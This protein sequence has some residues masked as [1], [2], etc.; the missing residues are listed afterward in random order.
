MT[1]FLFWGII[2]RGIYMISNGYLWKLH[3]M[4]VHNYFM[5]NSYMIF[6]NL[7]IYHN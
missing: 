4:L 7:K 2:K 6:Y 1:F 5:I 3:K